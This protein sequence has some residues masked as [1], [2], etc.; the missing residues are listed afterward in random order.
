MPP[1]CYLLGW[2]PI[3]DALQIPGTQK[4]RQRAR[5]WVRRFNE[6]CGGPLLFGPRGRRPFV[7]RGRLL[8]WWKQVDTLY[9]LHLA[10]L[11]DAR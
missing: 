1:K 8:G 11:R 10:R 6:C 5:R 3:L 9:E 2:Q 7:E 4:E